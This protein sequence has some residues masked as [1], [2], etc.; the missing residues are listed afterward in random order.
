MKGLEKVIGLTVV[1]PTFAK[2]RPN[3]PEDP[4]FGWKLS[5]PGEVLKNQNGFGSYKFD[6]VSEDYYDPQNIKFIRD[7]YV[8]S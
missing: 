7:L 4:H 1:H 6:D 3:D 8:V 5:A 2:S